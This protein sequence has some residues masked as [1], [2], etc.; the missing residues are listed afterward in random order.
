METPVFLISTFQDYITN[1]AYLPLVVVHSW[2]SEP[3]YCKYLPMA[4]DPE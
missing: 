1:Y 2:L 3:E 4:R